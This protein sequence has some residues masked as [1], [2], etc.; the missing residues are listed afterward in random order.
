MYKKIFTIFIFSFIACGIAVAQTEETEMQLMDPAIEAVHDL[1]AQFL[2]CTDA[3]CSQ[4]KKNFQEGD[5]VYIKVKAKEG[6]PYKVLVSQGEKVLQE[7]IL[8]SMFVFQGSG[9]YKFS[10]YSRNDDFQ[11]SIESRAL[12]VERNIQ[13]KGDKKHDLSNI[14]D[15]EKSFISSNIIVLVVVFLFFVMVIGLH[16][17]RKLGKNKDY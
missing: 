14:Y 8:P 12:T 10:F 11:N 5:S 7:I 3:K 9:N 1:D 6:F 4:E 2:F 15:V 16:V 13:H 17:I